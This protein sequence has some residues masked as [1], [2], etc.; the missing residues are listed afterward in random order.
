[1]A[2]EGFEDGLGVGDVEA[3]ELVVGGV[4][5]GGEARRVGRIGELVDVDEVMIRVPGDQ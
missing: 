2:G 1:M 3:V 5:D 4:G